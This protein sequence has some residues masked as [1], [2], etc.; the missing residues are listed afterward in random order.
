MKFVIITFFDVESIFWLSNFVSIT[1]S[2][3]P[4]EL[5]AIAILH[6]SI[7]PHINFI[8]LHSL[9]CCTCFYYSVISLFLQAHSLLCSSFFP[10]L[11]FEAIF[12]VWY[13]VMHC[14]KWTD[15]MPFLLNSYQ[16]GSLDKKLGG[17][18]CI[19]FFCKRSRC[20]HLNFA[21]TESHGCIR[22][23]DIFLPL[24]MENVMEDWWFHVEVIDELT[25][26]WLEYMGANDACPNLGFWD[27]E[28]NSL[29]T[30]LNG[31]S[32]LLFILGAI[33]VSLFAMCCW[34]RLLFV[35]WKFWFV[36]VAFVSNSCPLGK[37]TPNPCCIIWIPVV[38]MQ[39]AK[40]MN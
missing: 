22:I 23:V 5:F 13:C 14:Y 4:L 25:W 28:W 21:V 38:W 19:I 16:M 27:M 33:C 30:L 8:P 39:S 17:F 18:V 37:V 2:E 31:G 12:L 29:V 7:H 40:Q 24:E 15:S 32:R 20:S 10:C 34:L 36:I 9:C 11:L 35:T 26:N 6:L 1:F 3:Q